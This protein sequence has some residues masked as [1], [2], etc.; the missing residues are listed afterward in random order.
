MRI[1]GVQMDF[2][3]AD[4][5]G[6][7]SRMI[8]KIRQSRAEGA[9]LTIFPEC[10]LTG[11]CFN[12]IEEARPYAEKIPGPS[13][14][15]MQQVCREL[16]GY[17]V[18]GLLE[19][20]GTRIFNALAMVGPN[21]LIA[22]YRKTHLPYLGVDMFT[23]YGDRPFAVHEVDGVRIGLCICYDGGFPEPARCLAL[24]GADL[25]LLPTNW[26]PGA[27]PAAQYT[28]NARAMENTVYYAAVN[29]IGTERDV[30]FIG[31]SRI[32]DPLGKTIAVADHTDEAILYADI[33]V[34]RARQKHLIRKAGVNEV[35]RI[36]DRRPE[37]YGEIVEPRD[38]KRPGR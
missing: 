15:R 35:N 33:D 2:Q 12:R 19:S 29:R 8:E 20:D 31:R 13:V 16:G 9:T 27:E 5:E 6:N 11:Y 14:D 17:V 26:P 4:I 3:L 18:Y 23:D 25:I 22:S 24:L 28:I 1:A 37:L 7:L 10:A 30:P 32:C 36:A 21:G 38:L 34:A